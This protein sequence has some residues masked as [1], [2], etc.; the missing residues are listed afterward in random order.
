MCFGI[1]LLSLAVVYLIGC[2]IVNKV[3]KFINEK[4]YKKDTVVVVTG[5]AQGLGKEL[6]L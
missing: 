3:R 5:A 1:P 4:N 6:A 2:I